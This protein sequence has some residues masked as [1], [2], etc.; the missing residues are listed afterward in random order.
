M[1]HKKIINQQPVVQT[2]GRSINHFRACAV[3]CEE[4][5]AQSVTSQGKALALWQACLLKSLPL[6]ILLSIYMAVIRSS[7]YDERLFSAMDYVKSIVRNRLSE[8]LEACIRA[9]VQTLSTRDDF[10]YMDS[11][12]RWLQR[13][14]RERV[15]EFLRTR[16]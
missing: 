6:F 4:L 5:W 8:N 10:P 2:C 9:K 12:E 15:N 14:R 1:R 13:P 7:V 3:T 11:L 16:E